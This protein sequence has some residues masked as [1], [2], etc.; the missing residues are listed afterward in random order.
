MVSNKETATS[1]ELYPGLPSYCLIY[2]FSV[3]ITEFRN[4]RLKR[5]KNSKYISV[6]TKT[7]LKIWHT[8]RLNLTIYQGTDK[9]TI[10]MRFTPIWKRQGC[11]SSELEIAD[12]G[13]SIKKLSGRRVNFFYPER[14]HLWLRNQ[15]CRHTGFWPVACGK[16]WSFM[17]KKCGNA[18]RLYINPPNAK[19]ILMVVFHCQPGRWRTCVRA[20]GRVRHFIY[21]FCFIYVRRHEKIVFRITT[22][23]GACQPLSNFSTSWKQSQ[24]SLLQLTRPSFLLVSK[25]ANRWYTPSI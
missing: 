24:K 23:V 18:C 15:R 20:Y 13:L 1:I 6:D 14:Y 10:F 8:P 4:K 12:F 21:C 9:A 25:V 2:P 22:G 5:L 7:G 16:I 3:I 17:K 11:S 19:R